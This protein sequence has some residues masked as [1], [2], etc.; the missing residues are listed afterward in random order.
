MIAVSQQLPLTRGLVVEQ[1]HLVRE[2]ER[3]V[4][5]ERSVHVQSNDAPLPLDFEAYRLRV[6]GVEP[7]HAVECVAHISSYRVALA[8]V[9]AQQRYS[10]KRKTLRAPAAPIALAES[11]ESAQGR[12]ERT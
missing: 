2:I 9:T 8:P 11:Q 4:F 1:T 6:A 12:P 7:R 5:R 10:A 3:L